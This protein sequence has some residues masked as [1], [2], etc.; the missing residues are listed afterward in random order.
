MESIRQKQ[1]GELIRRY[2]GMILTEAG[3][4][5]YGRGKLVTVTDVK[6]TP[7]LLVA[8][9]YISVY[10]TEDK[11]EVIMQMEEAHTLLR[12]ALAAKIGKQMRRMP[13]LEFFLDDTIDEMYRVEALLNRVNEED[14]KKH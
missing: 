13:D 5:I 2:F 12:Q 6:M 14:K 9:I 10:G 8:K 11:P 3:T 7:D 4:N 1:V